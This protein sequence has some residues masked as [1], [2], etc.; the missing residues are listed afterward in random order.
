[1]KL[2]EMLTV[3]AVKGL[4]EV[5]ATASPFADIEA[6]FLASEAI[7]KA[8]ENKSIKTE[9]EVKMVE[10]KNVVVKATKTNKKEKVKVVR[11]EARI[12]RFF[13]MIERMAER[14]AVVISA[15]KEAKKLFNVVPYEFFIKSMEVLVESKNKYKIMEGFLMMKSTERKAV[16]LERASVEVVCREFAGK[17]IRTHKQLNEVIQ[18]G[19]S[20][21]CEK[22]IVNKIIIDPTVGVDGIGNTTVIRTLGTNSPMSCSFDYIDQNMVVELERYSLTIGKDTKFK[23]TTD[24]V[25]L[26]CGDC[27]TS[28]QEALIDRIRN[29]GLYKK[30]LDVFY[31]EYNNGKLVALR[32]NSPYG[33][34]LEGD[35]E[36][37]V[38]DYR[39]AFYVFFNASPSQERNA[40][41]VGID[42]KKYDED[43]RYAILDD[44]TGG[45]ITSA[46]RLTE[47][48]IKAL[49]SGKM[50]VDKLP[51]YRSGFT[52]K[53]AEKLPTRVAQQN[54]ASM[55]L[56]CVGNDDYGVL[57][58]DEALTGEEDFD[59]IL[60]AELDK[61]F[62]VV[63]DNEITDGEAIVS[64]RIYIDAFAKYNVKLSHKAVRG[65][66]FQT[67]TKVLNDKVFSFV[68]SDKVINRIAKNIIS[69][70]A[71]KITIIGNPN[72]IAY[73]V[74]SNACKLPNRMRMDRDLAKMFNVE[75]GNFE[76]AILA[77]ASSSDAKASLQAVGKVRCDEVKESLA[78]NYYNMLGNSLN[79]ITSGELF[80]D[81]KTARTQKFFAANVARSTE[82]VFT[83]EMALKEL[84]DQGMS[85]IRKLKV[86]VK[87]KNLRALFDNTHLITGKDASSVLKVVDGRIQAYSK[88]VCDMFRKELAIIKAEYDTEMEALLSKLEAN[89]IS[90]SDYETACVLAK[91]NRTKKVDGIMTSFTVKYPC[92]TDIEFAVFRYLAWFEVEE[93]ITELACCDYDKDLL[94]ELYSSLK[95][96]IVMIAPLNS[97]KHRLA[98]MD[99]DFDGI[100]S[101]FEESMVKKAIEND[102]GDLVFISKAE[103]DKSKSPYRP[104]AIIAPQVNVEEEELE[105][106]EF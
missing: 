84:A 75:Y 81:S 49:K 100:T 53:E 71:G 60:S 61:E 15:Q 63:I 47:D 70:Y 103:G 19:I 14:T 44:L 74:D 30:G 94:I 78:K 102:N 68:V 90:L 22:P 9:E 65:A 57:Y 37:F 39:V 17:K 5:K 6:A 83:L 10:V 64:E 66:A 13:K 67:R 29:F 72:K 58:I 73:I 85:A 80:L 51:A 35:I 27:D 45:G 89:E 33:K 26:S 69:K 91:A 92:P 56:A 48:D 104:G 101:F 21:V 1:M 59:A 62:G 32:I 25:Y 87:G 105:G 34:P 77:P 3:A 55:H 2:V 106:L 86:P 8:V 79:R 36:A 12:E 99:T 96:G 52:K 40:D 76:M 28:V 23:A 24:F 82:S 46:V 54:T 98:G 11:D 93:A 7:N 43:Q 38:N 97:L 41:L 95:D 4:E 18:K 50:T 20:T 16:K 88:T 42:A 31:P